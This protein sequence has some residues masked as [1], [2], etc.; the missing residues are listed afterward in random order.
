M[1]SVKSMASSS[2]EQSQRMGKNRV[3][4]RL[5]S[6]EISRHEIDKVSGGAKGAQQCGWYVT[7][8]EKFQAL[9][10]RPC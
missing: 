7:Y 10:F 1:C 4:A 6:K 5:L 9:D 8:N 3:F 2:N